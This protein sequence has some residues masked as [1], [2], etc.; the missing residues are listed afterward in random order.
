MNIVT[1]ILF[2][3]VLA[4][5]VFANIKWD[6]I[7]IWMGVRMITLHTVPA[8]SSITNLILSDI[9]MIKTD[10]KMVAFFGW[11]Y[12][13]ANAYGTY[14][15]KQPVYP[16]ADWKNIPETFILYSLAGLAMGGFFYLAA[17]ESIKH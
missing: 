14:E 6:G 11:T 5:T 1:V 7:G 2:W 8:I 4:P 12:L 9:K 15:M 13:F 16:V 17:V 10:W 3:T